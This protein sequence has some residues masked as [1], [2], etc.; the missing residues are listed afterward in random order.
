MQI[1]NNGWDWSNPT[2]IEC[3]GDNTISGEVNLD[4]SGVANFRFFT[5]PTDWG[6]GL[7]YSYFENLG[8]AIDPLLV[9]AEDGDSNFKFIGE[10]GVYNIT[11]D[12]NLKTITLESTFSSD[13]CDYEELYL[14]GAAIANNGWDWSNPA[15]IDV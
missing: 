3:E 5:T 13:E 11:L 7:N 6:S 10:S 8:Y 9:N 2:I 1:A 12:M 4:A 14:V 15:I